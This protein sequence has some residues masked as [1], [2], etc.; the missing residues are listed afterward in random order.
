MQY[1]STRNDSK[2]YDFCDVV[3]GGLARDGG[4]YVPEHYPQCEAEFSKWSQLNYPQLAF[5]IFRRFIGETIPETDLKA[6]IEK[7]YSQFDHPDIVPTRTFSGG[8]I[9]ELFH[10]P[11]LAF[12]DIALQF[13]GNLFEYLLKRSGKNLNIV[14]ATSGDTG[15][16]A[17]Y[18][19]KGK[20]SIRIFM[21]HPKGKVSPV[22]EL[23]MT[24][25]VDENVFNCAIEGTFDDCQSIV[26]GLFIDLEF[27]DR[28]HLGAVNSINWARILAQ[29]VY[30]FYAGFQFLKK[31]PGKPLKFSVPTGNFGDV[32]AGYVAMKMG[33]A[34]EKFIIATN[35]NNIVTTAI[36]K[37]LYQPTTVIETHSPAMDIQI[38]SNF[39]RILFDICGR[40]PGKINQLMEQLLQR[41]HFNLNQEMISR[42]QSIF[43]TTSVSNDETLQTMKTLCG[44]KIEID[45]HTAVGICAASKLGSSPVICLST[46][47]PAKFPKAF[48]QAIGQKPKTPQSIAALQNLP[49]KC[50]TLPN[51]LQSIAHYIRQSI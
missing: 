33:L 20:P 11:T 16:A 41:G 34:V 42:L 9:L 6:L 22:Q 37:G 36:Q 40:E 1:I 19:V 29:T 30:Y 49:T 7:S 50:Q 47:H 18:G 17:I 48:E 45:P 4:L 15:S 43:D 14:G 31:Y 51:E 27:R 10:G 2:S 25:I 44:E 8:E 38:S 24:T 3:L 35:E 46:A 28:Y 13:L 32:F 23:Q 12:K 39:E 21:L 5:E 26:K